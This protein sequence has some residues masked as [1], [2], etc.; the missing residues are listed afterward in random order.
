M[1]RFA[2]LAVCTSGLFLW[3]GNALAQANGNADPALVKQGEYLARAGDCIACHTAE[4]GKPFAGG[5]PMA[6]PIGTIYSTNITPDAGTGIGRDTL[7]AF[8]QSLRYGVSR[9]GHSLYPAMPFPSYSRLTS[10]DVHALYAYFMRG[11]AP[12]QQADKA[13]DIPWPLSMRWPLTFWRKLFAPDPRPF[14]AASGEPVL[15]RGAYL[16]EGLG[17]CGACHTPRS[18]TMQEKALSAQDGPAFLAG[19]APIDGWIATSLRGES[20]SGL[21]QWSQADIV[22]F[23]ATGRNPHASVFGGMS[24]VVLHSTQYMSTEDLSAIAHYLKSLPPADPSAG[25]FRYDGSTAAALRAG[26][27]TRPGSGIYIDS[28][29]SCHRSDGHGYT[30]VFPALAGNAAIQNADATQL[31]H[32]ILTGDTVPGTHRAPSAFT[33]PPFGWRMTDQQ[34]ADVATFVRSSW[35]NNGGTVSASD[36]AKVRKAFPTVAPPLPSRASLG[37]TP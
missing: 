9:H 15:A 5:R 3:A 26:D 37:G 31:I 30:A 6:T 8:D 29:A 22:S 19:G 12:V 34:V 4:G 20:H 33:M 14:V 11:V 25:P 21:G 7:E 36:V 32:V 18:L 23:L 16:V 1:G 17:H 27:A 28:C 24:D 2:N 35:G 13:S 10:D